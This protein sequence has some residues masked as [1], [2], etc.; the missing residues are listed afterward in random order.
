MLL[1]HVH[2]RVAIDVADDDDRHQVGRTSRD[3]SAAAARA[4]RAITWACRSS[5]PAGAILR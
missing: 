5:D 4:S 1:D 2:D 3:K